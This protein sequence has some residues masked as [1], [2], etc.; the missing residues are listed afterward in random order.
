MISGI[1]FRRARNSIDRCPR[2]SVGSG[3][4]R[5]PGRPRGG[6]RL[7]ARGRDRRYRRCADRRLPRGGADHQRRHRGT[8]LMV[9]CE[10]LA[11]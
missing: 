6:C 8:K 7:S 3:G 11:L 4:E 10:R 1:G 5:Q 2:A 9:S